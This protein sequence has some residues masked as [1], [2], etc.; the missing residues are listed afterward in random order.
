MNTPSHLIISAA[1]RKVLRLQ[2]IPTGAF[3]LGSVAPDLPLFALSIG[4][5]FY[6]SLVRGWSLEQAANY[7][8]ADLFF[9]D[10]V[11][12][13][14]HNLLHS[15]LVLL[16]MLLLLQPL[17]RCINS[18]LRW[19]WWFAL[20][21]LLHTLIDIP[22]HV[23]DGPLLLWPINWSLRFEAPIS[24]WDTDYFGRE[25]ALF[26]A[27]LNLVLLGYLLG[28]PVLRRMARR[29]ASRRHLGAE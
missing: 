24:Y 3:L 2:P 10:P 29:F 16:A 9:H 18:P 27:G 21:C 5:L 1:L 14:A 13:S 15:P 11:W 7:M 25:F 17:R 23:D 20:A 28:P 26:E 19:F 22:T 12:I 6:F 8:F 4:G